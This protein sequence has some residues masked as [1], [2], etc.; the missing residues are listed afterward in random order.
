V[1]GLAQ[2]LLTKPGR[3]MERLGALKATTDRLEKAIAGGMKRFFDGEGAAVAKAFERPIESRTRDVMTKEIGELRE[4]AQNPANLQVR[5]GKMLGDI[6]SFAPKIGSAAAIVAMRALTYLATQAPTPRVDQQMLSTKPTMRYSDQEL[7]V[8]ENKRQ[9]AFHPETVIAEL[10]AGKLNRDGIKTV[11]A[12]YPQLFAQ[13]QD[14][15]R[16]Q[17]MEMER[18]GLLDRMPYQQ[19]A[20]IAS[21]LEIAPDGTWK[22]DFMAMMQ[23]TKAPPPPPAQPQAPSGGA[24]RPIKMDTSVLS[25]EAQTIEG[26]T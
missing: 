26:R 7:S 9:A 3:Q 14:T 12:V 23:A 21:L 17:L 11:K 18:K 20:A 13:M 2:D 19:K 8:Y 1:L 22:P 24:G 4:V 25:T 16:T 6:P 10:Q 15:A 5:I